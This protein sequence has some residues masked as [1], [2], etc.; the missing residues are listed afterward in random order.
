MGLE[1]QLKASE[2]DWWLLMVTCRTGCS[3]RAIWSEWQGSSD[4]SWHWACL[5]RFRG[6]WWHWQMTH[7]YLYP[8]TAIQVNSVRMYNLSSIFTTIYAQK[9]RKCLGQ[10]W[11]EGYQFNLEESINMKQIWSWREMS[12]PIKCGYGS[13]KT[14]F[15][16]LR[17]QVNDDRVLISCL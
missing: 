4:A 11:V 12:H 13:M 7:T 5:I 9:P 17:T 10:S 2:E 16:I 14:R 3:S 15:S 6:T 8:T 1:K